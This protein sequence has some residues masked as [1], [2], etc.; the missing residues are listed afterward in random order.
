VI[1]S[2]LFVPGN[3]PELF[4][5]VGRVRPDAVV[6]DLEDAVAPAEKPAARTTALEALAA[7]RPGAGLV[8]VRVNAPG[9]EWFRDDLAAVTAG[10]GV[11][12]VV[13][14]KYE[15]TDQLATVRAALP[16]GARVVVGIESGLGVAD[17]RPLLAE[18]PDAVYFGA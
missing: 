2:L 18:G 14:P 10:R 4:G 17:A 8:L 3:R 1:R 15:T 5:K 16:E 7:E 11:D 9:T 6:A 13:L 12:G